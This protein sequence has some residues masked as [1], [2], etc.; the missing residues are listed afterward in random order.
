MSFV[1]RSSREKKTTEDHY[2]HDVAKTLSSKHLNDPCIYPRTGRRGA[3]QV[4]PRKLYQ[5]MNEAPEDVITWTPQGKSFIILDMETFSEEVLL[6]YFRHQKYSSF[7]RQ[8]NLYGFHKI[9]KGP[10]TGRYSFHS[11]LTFLCLFPLSPILKPIIMIHF[12]LSF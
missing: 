8:L 9:S 10:E 11:R 5:M 4:F 12:F 1:R 2:H 3:P 6:N 7:Q